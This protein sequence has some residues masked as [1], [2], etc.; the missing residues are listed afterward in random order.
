MKVVIDIDDYILDTDIDSN[1][2]NVCNDELADSLNNAV[3]F[4][5]VLQEIRQEIANEAYTKQCFDSDMYD[6]EDK[7]IDLDDVYAIIDEHI[8][9]S[10]KE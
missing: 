5:D 2:V 7:A 10:D 6:Y 3:K 4:S 9:R 1:W 8:K